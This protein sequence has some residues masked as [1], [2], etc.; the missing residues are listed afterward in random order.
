MPDCP[1]LALCLH[2]EDG[3]VAKL[4][5]HCLWSIWMRG[6]TPTGNRQLATGI[7]SMEAG[8]FRQ[9]IQIFQRLA[10]SEPTFAEA[11][12]QHG[13][14]LCSAERPEE[15]A[16]AYRRSLQLNP[17]HFAAA[18]S[19]GHAY[20]EQGNLSAALHCY[21]QALRIHPRLEDVPEAIKELESVLGTRPR[22]DA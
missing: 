19:L 21:R 10:T 5:E 17:Y 1:V 22:H 3:E 13:L 16:E 8:R 20:V 18:A 4:A 9:A 12:F 14:A 15:A 2:H 7:R 11:H 6:G